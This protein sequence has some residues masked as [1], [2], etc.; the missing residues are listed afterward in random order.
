MYRTQYQQFRCMCLLL[1]GQC[2]AC[3]VLGVLSRDVDPARCL[4]CSWLFLSWA[5]PPVPWPSQTRSSHSWPVAP[6]LPWSPCTPE[7]T[8]THTQTYTFQSCDQGM[9]LNEFSRRCSAYTQQ[10]NTNFLYKCFRSKWCFVCPVQSDPLPMAIHG[11]RV[12]SCD[13]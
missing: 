1:S 12:W 5:W 9:Q 11:K 6:D 7:H 8:H 13:I 10:W 4:P 2:H 3:E